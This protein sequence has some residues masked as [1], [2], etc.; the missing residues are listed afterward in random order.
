MTTALEWK[1]FMEFCTTIL[2][3]ELSTEGMEL[4]DNL[5]RDAHQAQKDINQVKIDNKAEPLLNAINLLN[6]CKDTLEHSP[7]FKY[8]S[9]IYH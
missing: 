7:V 5:F 4:I 9:L 1:L 8:V 3:E 2:D 6:D